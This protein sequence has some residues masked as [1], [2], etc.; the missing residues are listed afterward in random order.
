MKSMVIIIVAFCFAVFAQARTVE[1]G[2][3]VCNPGVVV[4]VPLTVDKLSDVGAAAF[5]VNYDPTIVACLGVDAGDMVDSKKMTYADTGTGQIVVVISSFAG[6]GGKVFSVRL[7]ARDGTAGQFSDVT[8]AEAQFAAKDGVSDLSASDKLVLKQGMVRVASADASISR[9]EEPFTVWPKTP[10]KGLTLMD[11]DSLQASDDGEGIV[12]SGEL[13]AN[14]S[15][16]IRAPLYGWHTLRYKLLSS[17]RAD[18]SFSLEGVEGAKIFSETAGGMTTY[19]AEVEVEGE[20]EIECEDGEIDASTLASLRNS[21]KGE[22]ASYPNVTRLILKGSAKQ[23][24]V[25]ADLGISPHI[26]VNGTVATASYAKPM[27]QITSFDFKTGIV[28]IKVTPGEGNAIRSQ[29]ATGCIHVYGT[30]DLREKMRYVSRVSIDVSGYLA[31]ETLGEAEL[32]VIM[33]SH[34]FL[35]IKVEKIIKNEG[36]TE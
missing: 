27:L 15:I 4:S 3:V 22:L 25:V 8:I 33:G 31:K 11:G 30:S 2:T 23:I 21:L 35:K 9:L 10:L 24:P 34:T 20:L 16:A 7:F 13:A 26:A 6:D 17:K 28:R 14:G 29:M 19:Y 5:V 32:H 1:T 18:L 36:D 12:V